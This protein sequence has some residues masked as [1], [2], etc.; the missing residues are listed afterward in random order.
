[1]ANQ[2]AV[3][4]TAFAIPSAAEI[5]VMTMSAFSENQTGGVGGLALPAGPGG[6]GV[7]LDANMNITLG[8]GVT[9]VVVKIKYTSAAGAVVVGFP[10]A[11][12]TIPV[13]ASTTV[14]VAGY[15]LDTT[16]IETQA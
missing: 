9:A 15:A 3:A 2:H 6:Q 14:Q 4:V 11:G 10:A 5:V 1:M 7:V 13:T 16:L 12:I 8:A